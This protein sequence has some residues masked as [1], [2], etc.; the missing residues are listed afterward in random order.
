ML[1]GVSGRDWDRDIAL[2]A[3]EHGLTDDETG[4]L[5][6]FVQ[7]KMRLDSVEVS[8]DSVSYAANPAA[9]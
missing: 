7:A 8:V 9:S 3:R 4:V 6:R 5:Q 1:A 2:Y